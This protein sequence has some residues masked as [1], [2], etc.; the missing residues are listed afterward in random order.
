MNMTHERRRPKETNF[1]NMLKR[2][3]EIDILGHND[4][5]VAYLKILA[6]KMKR[7][8]CFV[9]RIMPEMICIY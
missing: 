8:S 1:N 9:F 5:A 2:D 4:F 3:I 6:V 7:S